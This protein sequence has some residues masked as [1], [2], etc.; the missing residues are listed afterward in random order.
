MTHDT[1]SKGQGQRSLGSKVRVETDGR[2]EATANAV[3]N[4]NAR[5]SRVRSTR[6]ARTQQRGQQQE[7]EHHKV[8][9]RPSRFHC[10]ARQKKRSF[11]D[12]QN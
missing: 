5:D 10:A 7:Q 1:H 6:H 4:E 12:F 8:S 2:T 11:V 9:Y 3:G